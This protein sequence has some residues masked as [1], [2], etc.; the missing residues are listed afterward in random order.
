M[1]ASVGSL[2]HFIIQ[3]RPQPM[4]WCHPHSGWIFPTSIS[5]I[6]KV[7]TDMSRDL[8]HRLFQILSVL[9]ITDQGR[10]VPVVLVPYS[11]TL[12]IQE[13]D[14]QTFSLP[15]PSSAPNLEIYT[16]YIF[17]LSWG[18]GLVPS[19]PA[20]RSP[21]KKRISHYSLSRTMGSSLELWN[22]Q[23]QAIWLCARD[24]HIWKGQLVSSLGCFGY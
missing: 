13:E 24:A 7:P 20:T 12:R 23:P 10:Y 6:Q 4:G 19:Q 8:S 2:S 15:A 11:K 17:I 22:P 9:D 3:P 1:N 5:L 18:R 16:Y 21:T 14:S